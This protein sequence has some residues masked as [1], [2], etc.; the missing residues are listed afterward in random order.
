MIFLLL[1]LVALMAAMVHVSVRGLWGHGLERAKVFLLYQLAIAFGLTG[2][3]GFVGHGL[4]PAETAAR[5]GWPPS[6]NFQFELGSFELGLGIAAF[7]GLLIRNKHYWLG[8]ALPPSIFL[9]LAG[10]NHVHEALNGNFAPY[11]V[12][13]IA[14]DFLIPVSTGWF[15][16]RVFRVDRTQRSPASIGDGD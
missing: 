3:L 10:L 15:L 6:P 11:N 2:L 5:I 14:P 16:F 8:L 13:I 7:L 1:W 12:G 4:R 9:L